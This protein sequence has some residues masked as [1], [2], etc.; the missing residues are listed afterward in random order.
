MKPPTADLSIEST[1]RH[2][3]LLDPLTDAQIT[4]LAGAAKVLTLREGESLFRQ[5]DEAKELFVVESGRVRVHLTSPSGHAIE[6]FDA[7]QYRLSG[8]SAL[9]APHN[10]VADAEAVED[11]TVLVISA[12]DAE[13]ILLSDPAAGYVVMKRLAATISV[14]LRV[15][16]EQLI[17][18]LES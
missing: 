12:N 14:R 13:R 7:G 8:W 16:K 18:A 17:E 1:L 3:E 5:S 4:A 6:V 2:C 9:V 15:L 10:Y 11:S